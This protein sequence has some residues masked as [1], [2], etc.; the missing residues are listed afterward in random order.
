[1]AKDLKVDNSLLTKR[2]WPD[3]FTGG[4][5]GNYTLLYG[6]MMCVQYEVP[7]LE[8][9]VAKADAF[10]DKAQGFENL[11][12]EML[13]YIKLQRDFYDDVA[14]QQSNGNLERYGL[15][16]QRRSPLPKTIL[17]GRRSPKKQNNSRP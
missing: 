2:T 8:E 6:Y 12:N 7:V 3:Q 1:M 11:R 16:R 9:I 5:D 17:Y 14:K 10:E 4:L 15:P 13:K